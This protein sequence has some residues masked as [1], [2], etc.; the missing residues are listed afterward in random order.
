[1]LS[2]H[3]FFRMNAKALESLK[4]FLHAMS[5]PKATDAHNRRSVPSLAK[6]PHVSH[7]NVSN[8]K[9]RRAN[10]VI[11]W[12]VARRKRSAQKTTRHVSPHTRET[13]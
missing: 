3:G 13:R 8:R 12:S 2:A 6:E 7:R 11:G 1:M 10:N 9:Q 5:M 4:K